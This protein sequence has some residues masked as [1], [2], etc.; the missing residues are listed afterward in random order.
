MQ[1]VL[2]IIIP[3]YNMEKYLDH[4]LTS[5]VLPDS[6]LMQQFEVLVVIDG[7]TDRSSAIAHSYQDRYSCTF[8]V[9]DKENGN[10][11]SCIN[12][13]LPLAK[14]K[15]VKILDADD[16][17]QTNQFQ[18]F[19]QHLSSVDADMVLCNCD[20]VDEQDQVTGGFHLN[21]YLTEGIEYEFTDTCMLSFF[22]YLQMHNIAYRIEN[23]RR[24][25]YKQT[26]GI[27]YTD[28]EWVTIPMTTVRSFIF[29]GNHV[30]RYLVGREG[31]TMQPAVLRNK[32]KDMKTLCWSLI[33]FSEK[34]KGSHIYKE[35]I[36]LKI[37]SQLIPMYRRALLYHGY[38]SE[39]MNSFDTQIA[40]TYPALSKNMEK[41]I[42]RL[43]FCPVAYWRRPFS[44]FFRVLKE[45][46]LKNMLKQCYYRIC[47]Y[48]SKKPFWAYYIDY[49]IISFGK[50]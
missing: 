3:T 30:Y 28:Q 39:E 37:Q 26:Q 47:L 48:Y 15:Y 44:Y 29:F 11:G 5:L 32:F 35:Y 20:V 6:A 24:I 14:G 19:L 2:S 4:C 31:Q 23:L 13:A 41:W 12:A 43:N 46:G 17:F 22:P 34:F 18:L 10:Y 9:I 7:A 38:K 49:L 21:Q 42:D 50:K 33:V 25:Q 8:R 40:S 45:K 27:S 16:S 1:T 36:E